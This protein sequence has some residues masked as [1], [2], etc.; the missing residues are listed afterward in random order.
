MTIVGLGLG[1][2]IRIIVVKNGRQWELLA[3]FCNTDGSARVRKGSKADT[4]TA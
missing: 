1:N 4:T 3:T 2:A